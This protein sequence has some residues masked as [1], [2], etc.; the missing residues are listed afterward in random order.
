M[1]FQFRLDRPDHGEFW[2][3]H[4]GA[5]LDVEP[6]GEK[7]VKA[8]CWDIEDPTFDATAL[9]DPALLEDAP[10]PPKDLAHVLELGQ[11]C[12]IA[13]PAAGLVAQ[14]MARIYRVKD[15]GRR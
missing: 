9:C 1:D 7:R 11:L 3:A 14:D 12:R 5:L 10:H 8:M 4:C 2:L 6:C 13:L 15:D